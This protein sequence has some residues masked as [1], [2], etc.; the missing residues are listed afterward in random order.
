M[1]DQYAVFGNPIKHSLSP[2]IH[3]EFASQT[4]QSLVYRRKLVP[5]DSFSASVDKFFLEGGLGLNI[6]LP[7]K[8]EAHDY[9]DFLTDR[10]ILAGAA[11]ILSRM[12]DGDIC[13]DNSDGFGL[14][15]DIKTNLGWKIRSK[16]VLVLGAGGAVRGI[17][18]PLLKEKPQ[19]LVIANRTIKRAADLLEAF[20]D[21][22]E[23]SVCGYDNL[24]GRSFDLIINGTSAALFG[25]G[26][27]LPDRILSSRYAACYD[28]MYGSVSSAFLEWADK[29]GANV[30][31]GIGMLVEQ[32]AESFFIWRGVRPHTEAVIKLLRERFSIS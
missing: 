32:A 23:I 18:K 12:P 22:S 8:I 19:S 4:E 28:M 30:A 24:C 20:P 27:S 29:R 9:A 5:I 17:L 10:A 7:F 1:L 13:G 2:A 11:N 14:I 15:T 25:K 3:N 16:R 21:Q 31:D 26:L 6:T